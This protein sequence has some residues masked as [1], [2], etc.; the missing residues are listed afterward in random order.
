MNE[1]VSERVMEELEANGY[2]PRLHPRKEDGPFEITL[3]GSGFD[4]ADMKAMVK[5][6]EMTGTTLTLDDRGWFT[7]R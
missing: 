2:E 4:L 3:P 6:A 1:R 5:M 7:L